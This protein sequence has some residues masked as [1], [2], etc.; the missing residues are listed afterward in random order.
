MSPRA[1]QGR[2]VT[3][4]LVCLDALEPA[5]ANGGRPSG[6]EPWEAAAAALLRYARAADWRV[7]HVLP[8]RPSP[9]QGGWRPLGGLA[10]RP[11]EP[12]FHRE[13]PSAYVSPEFAATVC[14]TGR[15]PLVLVGMS[16][17]ASGLATA[18]DAARFGG[19]V[20][21]ATDALAAPAKEWEGL[22]SLARISQ[23]DRRFRLRL[24]AAAELIRHLP[25][26]RL[27]RGGRG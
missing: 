26:L 10:P 4:V 15:Q 18:L 14:E 20:T 6:P 19:R 7:V 2:S 5:T 9:G 25:E 11:T 24:S 1:V 21:V 22:R 16:V 3:P 23:A 27:I 17:R 13:A 8:R 12:V